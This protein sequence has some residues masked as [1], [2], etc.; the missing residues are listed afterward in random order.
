VTYDLSCAG[1]V[2]NPNLYTI[3]TQVIFA[4]KNAASFWSTYDLDCL[5]PGLDVGG[6]LVYQSKL[7]TRYTISGS[8]PNPTGLS[9]VAVIPETIELD[10]VASYTLDNYRIALNINNI[11]DRLNYSQSFGNRGTPAPGRTFVVSLDAAL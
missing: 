6:G 7:F 5:L 1:G 10:A 2:C 9:R 3:G 8:A 11:T 4:P